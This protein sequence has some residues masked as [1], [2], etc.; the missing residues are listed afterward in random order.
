MNE[1]NINGEKI[2]YWEEYHS[3]GKL[4]AKG[5]Y[6]NGKKYGMWEEYYHLNG[7]LNC[8]GSYINGK[9]EGEWEFY[10]TSSQ[11]EFNKQFIDGLP[12]LTIN[13]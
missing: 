10:N 13:N 4:N 11:F 3:N 8:K 9:E 6:L 5:N 2:G 12:I 7:E 1:L